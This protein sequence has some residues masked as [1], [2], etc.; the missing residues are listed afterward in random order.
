MLD[1]NRK[2]ALCTSTFAYE[3]GRKPQFEVAYDAVVVSV[4]EQTATFGVPGVTEHCY[5]LK[6]LTA[7]NF[8][9][10]T[11]DCLVLFTEQYDST[12]G[13]SEDAA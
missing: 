13:G 2:L 3:N 12:A 10:K 1:V 9:K 7:L 5:F 8:I 11:G 6:V 4:G